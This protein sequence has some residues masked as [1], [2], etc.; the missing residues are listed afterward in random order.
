ML[1]R[2][3]DQK[4]GEILSVFKQDPKYKAKLYQKQIE[5]AWQEMMGVWVN[6]ETKSLRVANSVLTIKIS[7]AALREELSFMKDKIRERINT[8][9][10][11]DYISEVVLR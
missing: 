7:S 8:L 1:T 4:I 2:K 3:N 6:R 9:L 10:G 5:Q 11:E